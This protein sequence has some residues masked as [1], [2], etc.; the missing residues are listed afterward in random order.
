[1]ATIDISTIS[2][3]TISSLPSQ[4]ISDSQ[5]LQNEFITEM[6]KNQIIG[7]ALNKKSPKATY[8]NSF[9][10]RFDT[11]RKV[12]GWESIDI[13]QNSLQNISEETLVDA[14]LPKPDNLA[15]PLTYM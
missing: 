11:L 2:L 13:D 4:V 3:A 5:H 7:N 6:K 12:H 9:S 10:D 8:I 1:M 15:G 14:I